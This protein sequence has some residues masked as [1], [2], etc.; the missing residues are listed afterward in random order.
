MTG[1]GLRSI[2]GLAGLLAAAC[3][4]A[5]PAYY[6]WRDD[7]GVLTFS[8]L[9]PPRGVEYE[10]VEKPKRPFGYPAP[11]R[12]EVEA[13]PEPV[14]NSPL[15]EE[16]VD[17]DPNAIT[18]ADIERANRETIRRNC[19][20]ARRILERL[21]SY[22]QIIVEGDDGVWRE[23]SE[24]QKQQELVQSRADVAEWCDQASQLQ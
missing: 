4:L 5:E 6:M 16:T 15:L 12:R 7:N 1:I 8:Q 10:T 17:L 24:E 21:T 2:V 13:P 11:P 20:Q 3:C 19:R 23:I 22:K 18:S 14:S 9:S